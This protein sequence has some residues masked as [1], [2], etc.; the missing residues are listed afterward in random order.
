MKDRY[1]VYIGVIMAAFLFGTM[2]I[3]L[4]I[5]GSSIDSFQLT[6]VRFFI[7]GLLL[8]PF[9]IKEMRDNDIR[10]DIK[11][12]LYLGLVGIICIPVSML[13]FQI[14]VLKSNAATASVLISMNTLF[15]L[16]FARIID[17][18]K[19]SRNKIIAIFVG[20]IGA[21]FMIKPWDMQEGNT[22]LGVVLVLIGAAAFGLYTV[23]GKKATDQVGIFVQTSFSFIEG[24]IVLAVINLII[25]KPIIAGIN[26]DNIL[27]VLYVSVFVT[28]LGYLFY[29]IAIKY[30]NAVTGSVTF[31]IKPA[32][33][34]I[35]AVLILHESIYWNSIVGIILVLI[36]S[37]VNLR[38]NKK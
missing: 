13:I 24:S 20:I 27:P 2:E 34:P 6:A 19:I 36:A 37:F 15:T 14:G 16:I 31:F 30:S 32:I 12:F 35:L 26:M 23:M 18:E 33:A 22:V 25:G 7:G 29:F 8:L 3:A 38:E 11:Q 4:K 10:L 17:N 21:L 5:A 28:G 1:K 9:A